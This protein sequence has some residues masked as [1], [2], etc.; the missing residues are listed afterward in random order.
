MVQTALSKLPKDLISILGEVDRYT[1]GTPESF[2][3]RILAAT[4][5]MIEILPAVLESALNGGH[6][7]LRGCSVI[8]L[9]HRTA[10]TY[11]DVKGGW[12][13]LVG[14]RFY[15]GLPHELWIHARREMI[16]ANLKFLARKI[17]ETNQFDVER[18]E[19]AFRYPD[20]EITSA[21]SDSLRLEDELR[22][23]LSYLS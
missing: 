7:D 6:K 2:R 9:V 16:K 12:E 21:E 17:K 19:Y 14:N 4:G 23:S 11:L 15:P 5:G 1:F 13:E 8:R 22:N 20:T 3:K 10:R 18:L